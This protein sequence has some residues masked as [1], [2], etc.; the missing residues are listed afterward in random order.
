VARIVGQ[1]GSRTISFARGT[2]VVAPNGEAALVLRNLAP[3]G[4]DRTYEA[5]IAAE[6]APEPA[7]LFEG[8]GAVAIPLDRPV[9][10]GATVMVTKEPAGGRKSP[11]SQPFVIVRNAAQS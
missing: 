6:G 1:P 8:G 2:L 7:G 11:S 3:A 4:N 10:K 9:P 5:W